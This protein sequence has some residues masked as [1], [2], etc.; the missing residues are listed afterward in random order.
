MA[1]LKNPYRF[2]EKSRVD[3]ITF[4]SL[5]TGYISDYG[6]KYPLSWNVSIGRLDFGFDNLWALAQSDCAYQPE[7]PEYA[8]YKGFAESVYNIEKDKD[9]DLN[10]LYEM[11]VQDAQ[12]TVNE[13]DTYKTLWAG[14]VIADTEF[15]FAGH[16][17]KHLCLQ[18]WNGSNFEGIHEDDFIE[19]LKDKEVWPFAR[20]RLFYKFCRTWTKDFTRGSATKEVEYQ[21]AFHFMANWVEPAWE[22]HNNLERKKA[23]TIALFGTVRDFINSPCGTPPHTELRL[24]AVAAGVPTEVAYQPT[25]GVPA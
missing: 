13:A 1:K 6:T 15:C 21:A 11:A 7:D 20:L 18:R 25:K 17:G 10:A 12:E 22:E 24:L 19:M 8:V 5:I 23:D 3:M 16:G 2:P 9:S 4:I 14:P